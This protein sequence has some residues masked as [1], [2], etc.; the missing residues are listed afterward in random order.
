MAGGRPT[1]W[2][3]E[4][5]A[6]AW[7]YADGGWQSQGDAVPMVVG[8]CLYIDRSQSTIYE[9]E[10]HEDKQFSDIIK[11]IKETQQIELFNQSLT[12]KYNASM[13]KLMLTKHGYSDKVDSDVT[14]GGKTI[15]NEWHIHPV[16]AVKDGD[17]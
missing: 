14:S 16:T 10:K 9:W 17:S 3:K 1:I 8:L 6:K 2:S 11:K 5:E 4:V 13:A 15:A 7:E 12:G